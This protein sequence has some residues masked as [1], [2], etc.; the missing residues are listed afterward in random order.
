[1]RVLLVSADRSNMAGHAVMFGDAM[2]SDVLADA[3]R[4]DG[5][6]VQ[7]A[8]FGGPRHN[9]DGER[10]RIAGVS[11]LLAVVRNH[12]AVVVGGGT[13]IQVDSAT[14]LRSSLM[15]LCSA[16]SI[17]GWVTRVPVAFF[18]VG[19]D[20]L[21]RRL[22]RI[23]Y[24]LAVW[25]REVW[26]REAKSQE[27]FRSY[28]GRIPHL[29]ADAALLYEN[30]ASQTRESGSDPRTQLF[31]PNR[32]DGAQMAPSGL[33]AS[34]ARTKR[35]DLSRCRSGA[36]SDLDCVPQ[37]TLDNSEIIDAM[38]GSFGVL[39]SFAGYNAIV[40]SRMHALYFGLL[41]GLPMVAVG[42]RPKVVAFA[43]E[44]NIPKIDAFSDYVI[45]ME[46]SGDVSSLANAKARAGVGLEQLLQH[47]NRKAARNT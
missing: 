42:N 47:L 7:I 21:P 26:V 1:M 38:D 12:D 19:C 10:L 4:A 9:S 20:P 32:K 37:E 6:E 40:A 29:A 35:L 5:H 39:E 34:E 3:I 30:S 41:Q 17:A 27:R 46:K 22:A 24:R 43:D 25:R 45:G 23:G 11:S 16:V 2:L 15:R 8:D 28:F 36:E 13:M 18:A 33:R 31:A 14:L 44:F